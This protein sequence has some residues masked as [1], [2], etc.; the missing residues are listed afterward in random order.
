MIQQ[1]EKNLLR[2]DRERGIPLTVTPQGYSGV[3][4]SK[5]YAVSLRHHVALPY[6]ATSLTLSTVPHCD[7]TN[8]MSL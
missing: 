4:D 8:D 3:G 7:I 2:I 6:C 1:N 5:H